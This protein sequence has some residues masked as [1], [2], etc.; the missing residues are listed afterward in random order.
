[1]LSRRHFLTCSVLPLAAAALPAR[2][3]TPA[4]G[5][6]YQI[7]RPPV[8]TTGTQVEVLGFFAYTCPHCLRFDPYLEQWRKTAPAWVDFKMVPVAWD[9][10]TE[11]FV[12]TYYALQALNLLAQLH[13]KFFESVI[14]Q[15]HPYDQPEKDILDFMVHAGVDADKWK[16]AYGSFG[17]A[18]KT[19]AAT[20]S[21]QSYGLEATPMVGVAGKYLTGPH[22]TKTRENCL[23]VIDFLIRKA[24]G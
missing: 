7:V 18:S 10:R 12:K 13:T 14:F 16:A 5:T 11:P 22:L 24:R 19:K 15:S 20:R 9:S 8:P 3:A 17:V 23:K 21:W 2:A 1:M 6:E 4:E